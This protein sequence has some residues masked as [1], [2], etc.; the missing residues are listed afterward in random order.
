M[1]NSIQQ[2][3]IEESV[4]LDFTFNDLFLGFEIQDLTGEDLAEQP[5][6]A[7]YNIVFYLSEHCGACAE[8][9]RS[10]NRFENLFCSEKLDYAIYWA[11]TI[12]EN[13]LE[14]NSIPKEKNFSLKGKTRLTTVT[15]SFFIIDKENTVKFATDDFEMVIKKIISDEVSAKEQMIDKAN[16]Y[17]ASQIA[18]TITDKIS[19]I[20]FAMT[21]CSDCAAAEKILDTQKIKDT[22]AISTIYSKKELQ[23]KDYIDNYNMFLHLYGIE[24]YPS[25]LILSKDNTYEFISET[26]SDMLQEVLIAGVN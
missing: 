11:D 9:L 22:F 18:D 6:N 26:S 16:K 1:V 8:I 7:D 24:W 13:L 10:I 3:A 25:F 12:P 17:I 5:L 14:K 2:P 21:D 23:D 15:P 19:L 20:Y 4:L